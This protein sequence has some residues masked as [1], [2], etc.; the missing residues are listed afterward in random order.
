MPK[1]SEKKVTEIQQEATQ[2][3][4]FHRVIT[5]DS[6]NMKDVADSSI[7]LVVTSPPYPMV[8]MWDEM[9]KVAG[10]ITYEQ[11]HDQLEQVWKEC[12]RVLIPGGTLSIN[13]G[14]AVRNAQCY[15]N[16]AT[17]IERCRKIGFTSL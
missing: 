13:I 4:T 15:P 12:Y 5:G 9:F 3:R 2:Q 6:R 8:A 7:H 17:T 14:D 1:L 16:S 10:A 11:M